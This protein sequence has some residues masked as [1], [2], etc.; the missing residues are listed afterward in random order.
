MYAGPVG[1]DKAGNEA[2]FGLPSAV[3]RGPFRVRQRD[4]F[5]KVIAFGRGDQGAESC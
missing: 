3:G 4:F 2:P 1:G 5:R